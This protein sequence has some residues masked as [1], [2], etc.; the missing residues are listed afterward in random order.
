MLRYRGQLTDWLQVAAAIA[1]VICVFG[2]IRRVRIANG[3][4]MAGPTLVP[5]T[6]ARAIGGSPTWFGSS[7][8]PYS[9]VEFA[10]YQ[11]PPCELMVNELYK[12]VGNHSGKLRLTYRNYPL[13][14][15]HQHA[16]AA[17][18]AAEI[19][20]IDGKFWQVHDALYANQTDLSEKTNSRILRE[21]KVHSASSQQTIESAR[22]AVA[23][24]LADG[25]KCDVHGT[26]T[27][28]MCLPDGRV[29]RL[30]SLSQAA[31]LIR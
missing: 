28:L 3:D 10:D 14:S 12:L 5:V 9:L 7:S 24:D 27:F 21:A 22:H 2:Y 25:E 17:A 23:V 13:R 26:P 11:C 16:D 19:A 29:Y 31:G 6:A 8:A 20:R 15:I 30:G 18:V 1:A 4:I